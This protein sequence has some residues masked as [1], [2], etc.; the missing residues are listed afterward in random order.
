VLKNIVGE[1]PKEEKR[2]NV[3]NRE[4]LKGVIST[5]MKEAILEGTNVGKKR[6]EVKAPLPV[7][8]REESG[9]ETSGSEKISSVAKPVTQTDDV[10]RSTT[11][12]PKEL[13]RMMRLTTDDKPPI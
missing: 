12:S 5:V 4:E 1:K 8:E 2:V 10:P 9:K 7:A 3:A 13:E 6:E 11:I